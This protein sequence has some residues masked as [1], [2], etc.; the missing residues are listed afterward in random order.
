MRPRSVLIRALFLVLVHALFLVLPA[1]SD[2]ESGERAFEAGRPGEALEQWRMAANGGD[3]R[4]MAAL[5]RLYLQGVGVMQDFVEAHKWFNLA[6][7]RGDVEAAKQRDALAEKMTPE[8]RAEAQKLARGWNP[9]RRQAAEAPPAPEATPPPPRALREAQVLLR[10]LGYAPGIPDGIWGARSVRA[11]RA[12]LRDAGLASSEVL[13]LE[14]LQAMRA[15][16][17][18]QGTGSEAPAQVPRSVE[19]SDALHR[20]AAGGDIDGVASALGSGVNVDGRDGHGWTALMHAVNK[21]YTVVV[22]QL[23]GAGAGVDV[24]AADGS[25]ALFMASVH[26]HSGIIELLMESGADPRV[27]GPRGKTAVDV[28]R[29]KYGGLESARSEGEGAGVL[30]LLQGMTLTEGA[31]REVEQRAEAQREAERAADDAAYARAQVL[32]T[33]AAYT[34]YLS[35]WP[36]GRHVEEARQRQAEEEQRKAE[37]ERQRKAEEERRRQERQPG[38]YFRDCPECPKMVVVPAG[39]FM[40]GSSSDEK[41][42]RGT[43]GPQHRVTIA[44][45]F[46]VGIYEVTFREWDAC[47]TGGGC[48]GYRPG[49]EGWGRDNRP[50]M[51]VNWQDAQAYVRWL[52]Q[53]TGKSY[54]LLSESEWEYVA[55]AGT[56][57]PFHA[58]ATILTNQANYDGSYKY[59]PGRK[60]QSRSQTIPVGSFSWNPFGLLNVHGNVAEWT[61][62]CW[63]RNYSGGPSDGRPWKKGNCGKRVIRGG[64]WGSPPAFSRSAQR[65]TSKSERRSAYVGFRVARA[66]NP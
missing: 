35:S 41:G 7:S 23:L 1:W 32:A 19:R 2:Y 9:E 10:Q 14:A 64:S 53:R 26:G 22:Q 8:E 17:K 3:A 49:D 33:E 39:S 46:A 62:D 60:G 20:A 59:G 31:Q 45:P 65:S 63:N 42:R 4:A 57:G 36:Q 5:G 51:N 56:K 27:Q 28:A 18:R 6:A 48:N 29:V 55:R 52:S 61:E 38:G 50:V 11:Y 66:V 16:A 24:R 40:M 43:E 47:V 54:R 13:T 21:G 58:G 25:T 15:I 34:E 44:D 30:A 12:F 37:E